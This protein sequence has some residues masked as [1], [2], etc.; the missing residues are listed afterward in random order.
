MKSTF[1]RIFT[2]ATVILLVALVLIGTFFQFL[3]RD[4][5]T[6]YT[7]DALRQEAASIAKLAS[8]YAGT[9]GDGLR[10]LE[11]QVNLDVAANVTGSD[12]L[13][14]DAQGHFLRIPDGMNPD[15]QGTL[16]L[17]SDF[18]RQVSEA[19]TFDHTGTIPGL[20]EDTRNMVAVPIF[21]RSTD[22]C[23]GLVLVSHPVNSISL[24][25]SR[26]SNIFLMVSLLVVLMAIIAMSFFA[27]QQSAPLRQM[28]QSAVA[29]GHGN[30]NVRVPVDDSYPEDVE[31]LARAFN[32]MA[33]E[34]Q[35]SEYQ[36]QEFVANVSHELKTP[37]TTIAGYIDGILD[38][39]IPLERQR[40]YLTIVSDETKRLS[41]LVR[42]MLDISRLQDQGGIPE[43]KKI[44]FDMEECAGQVL[45]TFEQK[46]N[47]KGLEVEVDMPEHPVYTRA[48]PDAVTQVI[49]N[50]LDNAVKFCP[51][52][53]TL[54][55][56]IQEGGGRIYTSISNSGPT[57]PP[58]ELP[59][60]FDRFHKLDKSRTK[61]RDGWGL[62]LYIVKTLVCSHGEDI[63]VSSQ[64]DKTTFTFTMPL[65]N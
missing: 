56:Q 12:V 9:D 45:I 47:D 41:R 64:N 35:K 40:H 25:M 33:Q 28:T 27:H 17:S 1:A 46:I 34:L 21:S 16:V 20:Y 10:T 29:F 51:R 24:I 50:L 44:H 30:L 8:S 60:V 26:I 63:A 59:L 14:F 58:E 42:S 52:G 36:R 49:Y 53:G 6:G 43:E 23:M 62:G 15:K 61:N 55:L 5:L 39:T 38:G 2:I 32:N 65:V 19:G 54:G 22:H 7:M 13:V 37:M 3:V 4:Y 11:F 31:N 57:I 18:I 48:D